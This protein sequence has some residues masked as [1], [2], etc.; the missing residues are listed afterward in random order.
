VLSRETDEKFPL[1][2][3]NISVLGTAAEVFSFIGF[4]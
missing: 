2:D 3:Q 4:Q 1:G